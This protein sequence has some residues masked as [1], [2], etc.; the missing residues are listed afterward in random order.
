MIAG[1]RYV[2]FDVMSELGREGRPQ[3]KGAARPRSTRRFL[4]HGHN[5]NRSE[6]RRK[7]LV[8]VS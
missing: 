3:K 8:K 4:L 2:P 5:T 7:S 1:S 6:Y